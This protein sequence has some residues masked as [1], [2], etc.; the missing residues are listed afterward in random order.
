MSNGIGNRTGHQFIKI[1]GVFGHVQ[2]RDTRRCNDAGK[3]LHDDVANLEID[4]T[5]SEF[6]VGATDLSP[7]LGRIGGRDTIGTKSTYAGWTEFRIVQNYW[8]SAPY[9]RSLNRVV[10]I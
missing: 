7:K 1:R 6:P 10:L 4:L 2:H 9:F 8:V 5:C 3:C